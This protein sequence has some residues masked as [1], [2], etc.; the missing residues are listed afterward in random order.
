MIAKLLLIE[1]ALSIEFIF[2]STFI[3]YNA[4]TCFGVTQNPI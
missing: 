1:T 2:V 4:P 3:D